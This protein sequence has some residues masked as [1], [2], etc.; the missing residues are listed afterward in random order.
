M[1]F[2]SEKETT[3]PPAKPETVVEYQPSTA[4]DMPEDS[5]PKLVVCFDI[6]T[7]SIQNLKA[8]AKD[9][10]VPDYS[11]MTKEQLCEVL[12]APLAL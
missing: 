11:H 7:I 12:L 10:K 9:L 6:T 8:I 4:R 5:L 2:N 1:P 3:V